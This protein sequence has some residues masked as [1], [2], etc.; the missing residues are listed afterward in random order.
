MR[1]FRAHSRDKRT[2]RCDNFAGQ[3]VTS[4]F[5]QVAVE[6]GLVELAVAVCNRIDD[7]LRNHGNSFVVFTCDKD[8][9]VKGKIC[10]ADGNTTVI[11]CDCLCG[12]LL[13]HKTHLALQ[14]FKRRIS[15]SV[16]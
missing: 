2:L 10:R 13:H 4:F 8:R 16:Q 5:I 6:G 3:S 7:G 15:V 9:I 11:C 14:F 1:I 12:M